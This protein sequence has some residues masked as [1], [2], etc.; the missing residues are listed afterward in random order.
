MK[1]EAFCSNFNINIYFIPYTEENELFHMLKQCL[2]MGE[3]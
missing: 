3:H 2:A 1:V